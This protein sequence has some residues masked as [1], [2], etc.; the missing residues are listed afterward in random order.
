M[1]D[2]RACPS[3]HIPVANGTQLRNNLEKFQCRT[4][5]QNAQEYFENGVTKFQGW[6]NERKQHVH[7]TIRKSNNSNPTA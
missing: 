7:V 6:D 4:P 3:I 1:L 5:Q 2:R